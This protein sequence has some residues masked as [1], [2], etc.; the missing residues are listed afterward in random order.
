MSWGHGC[1]SC[2]SSCEAVMSSLL[3]SYSLDL[4][5]T[6]YWESLCS[7]FFCSLS[8]CILAVFLWVVTLCVCVHVHGLLL[9]ANAFNPRLRTWAELIWSSQWAVQDHNTLC[10]GSF[11]TIAFSEDYWEISRFTQERLRTYW[12][13]RMFTVD[14]WG[15]CTGAHRHTLHTHTP[16]F[17]PSQNCYDSANLFVC[18]YPNNHNTGVYN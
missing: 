14:I 5:S 7:V 8:V 2:G 1:C 12:T 9:L 16:N 11:N 18:W 3:R 6:L 15:V 4:F 17:F 13:C 10:R